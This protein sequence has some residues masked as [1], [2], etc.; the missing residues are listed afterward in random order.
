MYLILGFFYNKLAG[1]YAGLESRW[2]NTMS[3][4]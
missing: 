4:S 1:N 2:L 3:A